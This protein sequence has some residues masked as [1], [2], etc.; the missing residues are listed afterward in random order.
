MATWELTD[1]PLYV[2][3]QRVRE[4]YRDAEATLA[5]RPDD[6]QAALDRYYAAKAALNYLILALKAQHGHAPRVRCPLCG[7]GTREEGSV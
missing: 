2:A 7:Q 6:D 3:Y 4:E 5:A 1:H